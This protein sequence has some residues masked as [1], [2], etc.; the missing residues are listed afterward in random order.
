MTL[1]TTARRCLHTLAVACVP[2]NAP[3]AG[4]QN[5]Q[6]SPAALARV[7]KSPSNAAFWNMVTTFS[8]PGGVLPPSENFT[9]NEGRFAAIAAAL[10][11]RG[12]T[13]GAYLGV[14]PEQN[15]RPPE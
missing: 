7:P 12:V 1:V 13:G 4:S 6:G 11:D 9:S 15:H 10:I 14:G 5:S 8:E 2:L 3:L